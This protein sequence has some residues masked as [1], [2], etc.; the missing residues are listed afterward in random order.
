[1]NKLFRNFRVGE[2][3]VPYLLALVTLAIAIAMIPGFASA[4]HLRAIS[5]SAGYIGIIAIG[6]TLVILLGG[7]DLS[8]AY[9]LNLAA[10][11]LTGLQADKWG[12]GSSILVVLILGAV[13]G[14][15]NG[16]GIAFLNISPLVM[17]LGMNS[18]LQGVTLLYTQGTPKGYAPQIATTLSTQSVGVPIVVIMWLGLA[19][20]VTVMLRLTTFG[21]S[22]YSIGSNRVASRLCAMPI[23]RVT[24]LAY[25]LSGISAAVGAVLLVGYSGQAYL[26][27]GDN[28]LLPSIAIVVIGGT[29]IFGGRGSYAQTI[30]G[31]LLLTI[32]TSALV[33]VQ[34]GDAGKEVMYGGVILVMMFLNRL[35]VR[36]KAAAHPVAGRRLRGKRR[37]AAAPPTGANVA[38]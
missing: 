38:S 3:A 25:T 21:R 16:A 30:A 15:V 31:A 28:Y 13:V 32:A 33:T 11:V 4:T 8:V 14:T 37:A 5:S 9:M 20:A 34:I 24:V 29:S 10:V 1:M 12:G 19:I 23:K 27:M 26:G 6:Q 22:L 2:I 18:I 7:I 36:D 17:T 35:T